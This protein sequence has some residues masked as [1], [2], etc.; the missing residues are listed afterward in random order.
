MLAAAGFGSPPFFCAQAQSWVCRLPQLHRRP[1]TVIVVSHHRA[2]LDAI[3]TH[4][5]HVEAR[6][7]QSGSLMIGIVGLVAR[8]SR[9]YTPRALQMSSPPGSSPAAARSSV[10][11]LPSRSLKHFRPPARERYTRRRNRQVSWQLDHVI[12]LP[13]NSSQC[14]RTEQALV[15]WAR[16]R[17]MRSE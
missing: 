10:A 15:D 5:L 16:S 8:L 2:F 9:H 3:C 14:L 4:I 11:R 12:C 17:S 1:R 13:T 7:P 6:R